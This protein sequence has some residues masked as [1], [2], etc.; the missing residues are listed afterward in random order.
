LNSDPSVIQQVAS[1][2]TGYGIPAPLIKQYNDKYSVTH[3][4]TSMDCSS[5]LYSSSIKPDGLIWFHTI[6]LAVFLGFFFHVACSVKFVLVSAGTHSY[7]VILPAGTTI[8][9][10]FMDWLDWFDFQVGFLAS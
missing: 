5:S 4:S 7:N 6:F 3:V 8:L 1:R 2:Y 9:N 10:K